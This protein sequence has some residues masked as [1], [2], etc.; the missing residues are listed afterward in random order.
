MEAE[1]ERARLPRLPPKSRGVS[2]R[3]PTS[4]PTEDLEEA[5][6][7]TPQPTRMKASA[8]HM[9][10]TTAERLSA[11]RAK[12]PAAQ[13]AEDTSPIV[14]KRAPAITRRQTRERFPDPEPP[15]EEPMPMVAGMAPEPTGIPPRKAIL[16]SRAA[17]PTTPDRT[18]RARRAK[19]VSFG[20]DIEEP[21]EPASSDA[22]TIKPVKTPKR[23]RRLSS[24]ST[25]FDAPALLEPPRSPRIG[26]AAAAE[27]ATTASVETASSSSVSEE[28]DP[29][30]STQQAAR[31]PRKAPKTPK[32]RRGSVA[33]PPSTPV[34][35]SLVD[36]AI[37]RALARRGFLSSQLS[38]QPSR[39]SSQPSHQSSE[40]SHQSSEPSHQNSQRS[41]QSSPA[42]PEPA[43]SEPATQTDT[44]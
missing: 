9:G 35:N 32:R 34:N 3:K 36:D 11:A 22:E 8:S 15:A 43:S 33:G 16:R 21:A 1:I 5:S 40:P 37:S 12:R 17:E 19:R 13:A 20:A 25:V 26:A 41:H 42:E 29:A 44:V 2:P 27:A 6:V 31:T 23:K 7:S 28:I 39:Q 38:S 14:Y 24:I 4:A 10:S 30:P 18:T